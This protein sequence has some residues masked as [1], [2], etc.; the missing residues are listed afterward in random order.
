M[1]FSQM[2]YEKL[3]LKFFRAS[4]IN[5]SWVRLSQLIKRTI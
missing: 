2:P 5:W 1:K 4:G 3:S